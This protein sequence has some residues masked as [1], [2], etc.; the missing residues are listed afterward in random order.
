LGIGGARIYIIIS[1]LLR[2]GAKKAVNS[3][4]VDI[5][6]AG[7]VPAFILLYESSYVNGAF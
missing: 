7:Y 2:G 1:A 6:K 4:E 5:S 3:V